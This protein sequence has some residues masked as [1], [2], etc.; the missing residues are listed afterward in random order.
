MYQL[1][2]V[3]VSIRGCLITAAHIIILKLVYKEHKPLIYKADTY[4]D[5]KKR[6]VGSIKINKLLKG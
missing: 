6:G 4:K 1:G 3:R 5:K 2:G